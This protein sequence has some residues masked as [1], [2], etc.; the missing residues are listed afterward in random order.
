MQHSI[1]LSA[2]SHVVVFAVHLC[3]VWTHQRLLVR[4]YLL[5][6]VEVLVAGYVLFHAVHADRA[7]LLGLPQVR[8]EGYDVQIARQHALF[9]EY[10]V[11]NVKLVQIL[12]LDGLFSDDAAALRDDAVT[13]VAWR[14]I[15]FGARAYFRIVFDDHRDPG[16]S[17]AF[18]DVVCVPLLWVLQL[19]V[20]QL[21]QYVVHGTSENQPVVHVDGVET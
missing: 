7:E 12:V 16:G 20:F 3:Y 1:T 2:Q 14:Q 6:A 15:L 5:L 21:L 17:L 8:V 11:L 13:V 4:G 10:F 19:S 9:L 18:Q